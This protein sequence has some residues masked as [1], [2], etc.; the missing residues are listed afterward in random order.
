MEITRA[1]TSAALDIAGRSAINR[2]GPDALPFRAAPHNLEAEQALLGAMLVNNDAHERV[3]SFLEAHH[4]YDPLHQQIYETASKLIASGKQATP[5]TLRTFFENAEPIDTTTT[6]PV[7][8]GRL[9]INATTIINARDYARTIHDLYTRRQL[10]LI[11]EDLVNAAYESP[12]DFDPSEQ[13]E[14]LVTR[15]ESLHSAGP[16]LYRITAKP[17][18]YVPADNIPPR[19]VMYGQEIR[20]LTSLTAGRP[21]VGKTKLN[22][23]ENLAK[24]AGRKLLH[25]TPVDHFHSWCWFGEEPQEEIDRLI[26]AAMDHHQITDADLEERLFI[27]ARD[28]KL[29]VA[30]HGRNGLVV[31]KPEVKAL[32]RFIRENGIESATIDPFVKSHAVPENDNVLIDQVANIFAEIA[33]ST[34]CHFHLYH[35]TRKNGGGPITIE[36]VR[37]GGAI[38][39]SVRAARILNVMTAEEATD[40]GVDSSWQHIRLDDGKQNNLPPGKGCW[41]KLARVGLAHGDEAGVA[42]PW[43]WPDPFKGVNASDLLAVQKAVEAGCFRADPQAT[44]WVGNAVAPVLGLDIEKQADRKRIKA[45]LKSWIDNGALVE[46]DGLDEKRKARTFI[47]VGALATG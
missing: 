2:D 5:I 28:Q 23:T 36:D 34:G 25:D 22:I 10:I 6:V 46:V 40:A 44:A 32:T 30:T 41:I 38:I 29:I 39:G 9:A 43:A 42:T 31:A 24:A 12:V 3:S 35:H 26:T 1:S 27:S 19:P 45:L 18:Q 33:Y 20:G 47:E 8:L 17:Y 16:A 7:Y 14:E 21:G 15:A 4:F 11:G 37:G 13:L